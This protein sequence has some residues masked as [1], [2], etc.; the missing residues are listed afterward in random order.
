MI[1]V[2]GSSADKV[3]PQFIAQLQASCPV[4]ATVDEDRPCDYHVQQEWLDDRILVR[5][6]GGDCLGTRAVSAIFVRHAVARIL[7]P[8]HLNQMFALQSSLN[9]KLLSV[10]CP[11][12]NPPANAYS[13]Y[14][15][16]FQVGLLA[17][18]GFD[19]PKT[20]VT[21]IPQEARQFHEEVDG[22]MIFK[23]VS[24]MMTFAQVF[25]A[26]RHAKRLDL[27]PYCPTLFQEYI[28]G[29]DYRVHVVGDEV[30]VTKLVAENEDYRRSLLIEQDSTVIV[31]SSNLPP[32]LLGKCVALTKKLGLIVSG[33]DFKETSNGRLVAL[34]L[35]PYPQFTFYE[36]R[37]G[38]PIM[39]AIITYLVH[40]QVEDPTL[41]V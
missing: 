15:K 6:V 40:N 41:L 17:E 24:N 10:V 28:E 2:L 27:L 9:L 36:K 3:Y 29:V 35:N 39:S 5:I 8:S 7:N 37:S 14:S 22:R 4:F 12:I 34:E 16:P 31:C 32:A 26:D 18:A 13:N 23:G 30:F 38:Q 11:V 33:I 20:L 25:Q 1:L 21:N 19:V